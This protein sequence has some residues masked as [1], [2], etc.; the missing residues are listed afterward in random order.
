MYARLYTLSTTSTH[1]SSQAVINGP[2]KI[3]KSNIQPEFS[4]YLALYLSPQEVS[5]LHFRDNLS[6]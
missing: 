3:L 1:K 5:I 2:I 4:G 6:Q